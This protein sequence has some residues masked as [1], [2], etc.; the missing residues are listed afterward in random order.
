MF[1]V[2]R[3]T[4][5][6]IFF[7]F[8]IFWPNNS[9]AFKS[10]MFSYKEYNI[11]KQLSPGEIVVFDKAMLV[12]LGDEEL[13]VDLFFYPDKNNK[14]N[15]FVLKSK[16]I[17]LE[18]GKAKPID[19]IF[20]IP[21]NF[22]AGVYHGILLAQSKDIESD[23]S[24]NAESSAYVNFN[25]KEANYLESIWQRFKSTMGT[26]GRTSYLILSLFVL[27]LIISIIFLFIKIK[28]RF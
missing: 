13:K 21:I 1:F 2:P 25:V 16:E 8:L 26:N 4:L 12:N 22:K 15:E 5:L 24:D 3:N 27:W 23:R 17:F 18:A 28:K 7:L 10:L 14:D 6:L 20:Q 19:L 11:D 9:Q